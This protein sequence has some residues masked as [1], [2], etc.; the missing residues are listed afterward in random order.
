MTIPNAKNSATL[1]FKN[2]FFYLLDTLP[3][4]LAE[5]RLFFSRLKN[6]KTTAEEEYSPVD[7]KHRTVRIFSPS[8]VYTGMTSFI[9]ENP[10][11]YEGGSKLKVAPDGSLFLALYRNGPCN[12][13]TGK[14]EKFSAVFSNTSKLCV[15]KIRPKFSST[16]V[17]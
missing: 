4:G 11:A 8:P 5:N 17:L 13:Y 6:G 14:F 9:L 7:W 16:A 12:P 2:D 3:D 1:S 15:R 10:A